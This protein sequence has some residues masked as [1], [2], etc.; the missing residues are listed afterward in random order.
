MREDEKSGSSWGAGKANWV[1]LAKEAHN[2]WAVSAASVGCVGL[3]FPRWWLRVPWP[4][5]QV[6][7]EL[8]VGVRI[9]PPIFK[10]R[11]G[12]V[13]QKTNLW[14]LCQCLFSVPLFNAMPRAEQPKPTVATC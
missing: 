5:Q 2:S 7:D 6:A 9:S 4:S 13:V 11:V 1:E 10:W 3:P 8:Y 14:E 12:A